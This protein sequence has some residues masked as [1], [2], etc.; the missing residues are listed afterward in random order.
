MQLL[1]L[2]PRQLDAD[3]EGVREDPGDIAGLA[4]TIAERGLLQ[5][6]GVV[7]VG[8][9]RYQVVAQLAPR[10]DGQLTCETGRLGRLVFN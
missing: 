1:Y 4:A 10:P 6:L 2:D 3:P 7:S 9:G 5:P 8:G